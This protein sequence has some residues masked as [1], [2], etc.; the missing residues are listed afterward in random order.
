M[1]SG[2]RVDED[3]LRTLAYGDGAAPLTEAERDWCVREAV[4]AAEGGL[5]AGNLTPLSD[6]DLA[7]EV[8]HAWWDYARSNVL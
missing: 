2:Q 3:R 1:R 7:T 5:Q 6:K 4:W 8:L